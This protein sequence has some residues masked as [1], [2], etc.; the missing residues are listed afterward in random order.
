[1]NTTV[2]TAYESATSAASLETPLAPNSPTTDLHALGFRLY[3][4]RVTFLARLC[5]RHLR[6]IRPMACSRGQRAI[7]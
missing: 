3:H 2:Q 1:M 5:R 6:S 4:K 7:M